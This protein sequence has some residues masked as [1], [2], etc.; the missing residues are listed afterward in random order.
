MKLIEILKR[1]NT[2]LIFIL[3]V[4]A[5]FLAGYLIVKLQKPITMVHVAVDSLHVGKKK[6]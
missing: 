3:L 5:I 4:T 2:A 6:K 1:A